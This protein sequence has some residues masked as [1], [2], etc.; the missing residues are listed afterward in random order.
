[1]IINA[2]LVNTGQVNTLRRSNDEK[3]LITAAISFLSSTTAFAA[4]SGKA[5]IPE[6]WSNTYHASFYRVSNLTGYDIDI[7][8]KLFKNNN[9]S[10]I[11]TLL[12]DNDNNRTSGILQSTSNFL[13]YYD[14]SASIP[15]GSI[16]FTLSAYDSGYFYV[17]SNGSDLGG[18]GIILWQQAQGSTV[19]IPFA[20]I[21]QGNVSISAGS[22][23]SNYSVPINNGLPF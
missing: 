16:K 14:S 23:F 1:M 11:Q 22:E 13:N 10:G 2:C 20:I 7:T 6:W 18:Y 4:S 3:S 9:N 19:D 5:I 12:H 17:N 15:D 8:V 21:A